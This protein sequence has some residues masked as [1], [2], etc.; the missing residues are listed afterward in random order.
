[1]SF[2]CDQLLDGWTYLTLTNLPENP[3]TAFMTV[4]L[5]NVYRCSVLF[6]P[7]NNNSCLFTTVSSV[8]YQYQLSASTVALNA[9]VSWTQSYILHK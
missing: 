4:A 5:E 9:S 1:M 6:S 8:R 7:Q 2:S 3:R